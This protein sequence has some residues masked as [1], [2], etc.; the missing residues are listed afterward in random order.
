MIVYS[1]LLEADCPELNIRR[2]YL[3]EAGQ[4]L[5]GNWIVEINYGRIGCKGRK[6][7][8][9]MDCEEDAKRVVK[10]HLKKRESAVKRIGVGYAAR[11]IYGK[12]WL[13]D[14]QSMREI[15]KISVG[16]AA[17]KVSVTC[18]LSQKKKLKNSDSPPCVFFDLCESKFLGVI[19]FGENYV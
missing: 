2:S 7:V 12:D 14:D 18:E 1:I 16:I 11:L 8:I 15:E 9:L 13:N 4:D 5:F 6:K 10:K 19:Y 17:K 3:I